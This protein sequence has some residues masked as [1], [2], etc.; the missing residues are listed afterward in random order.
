ML[1]THMVL[2]KHMV[3]HPELSECLLVYR[4]ATVCLC[5]CV[6]TRREVCVCVCVCVY[7]PDTHPIG[8]NA[9]SEHRQ[10]K[11]ARYICMRAQLALNLCELMAY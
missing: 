5:M 10:A 11:K 4:C 9:C 1:H 7:S 8:E 2:N 6:C 3:L